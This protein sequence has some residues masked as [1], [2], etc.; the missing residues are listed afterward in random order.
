MVPVTLKI[1]FELDGRPFIDEVRSGRGYQSSHGQRLHFGL[2]Q[3]TSIPTLT[4]RWPDGSQ[5]V[6]TDVR[7]NRLVTIVQPPTQ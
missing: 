6:L 5:Q 7:A 4:I 3:S 2:G 1:R